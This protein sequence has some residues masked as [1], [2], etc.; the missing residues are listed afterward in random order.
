MARGPEPRPAGAAAPGEAG[1][2]RTRILSPY[3]GL[4]LKGR[5]ELIQVIGRGGMSTVFHAVD[6]VRL[7]ARAGRPDVA[8]KLV[9]LAPPHDTAARALIH[10]EAQRMLEL[11]HPNIVRVYD[12]DHD[13][14]RHFL[15]ME[16]LR[17][18]TLAAILRDRRGRGLDGPQACG[19][20]RS[21]GAALAHAHAHGLIHGDLK[22]GNV[23]ICNDGRVKVL[24]FG[25]AQRTVQAPHDD[26]DATIRLLDQVGAL[27]PRFA[28]PERLDGCPPTPACDLFAFGLLAYMV[29]SGAHPFQRRTALEARAEGVGPRRPEGL[30]AHRWRALKA[31]LAFDPAHRPARVEEFTNRFL[32]QSVLAQ[33]FALPNL[34]A[35]WRAGAAFLAARRSSP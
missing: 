10:R 21:V 16:L 24:D 27:T 13:G 28:S 9:T 7:G 14:D 12:S 20:I 30:S 4:R 32:A 23:F 17:G 15:V 3:L 25:L 19:C 18:R 33:A 2:N 35:R 5:Y 22:P 6:H 1:G 34:R 11:I 29:L 31:L 8:I 26:E